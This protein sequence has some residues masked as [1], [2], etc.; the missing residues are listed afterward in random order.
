MA[1]QPRRERAAKLQ[2]HHRQRQ[3]QR[4]QRQQRQRQRQR[5]RQRRRQMQETRTD[6]PGYSRSSGWAGRTQGARAGIYQRIAVSRREREREMQISGT[7]RTA[8]R[9]IDRAGRRLSGIAT[10]GQILSRSQ[11]EARRTAQDG[12]RTRVEHVPIDTGTPPSCGWIDSLPA[13]AQRNS[14]VVRD[15]DSSLSASRSR[16]ERIDSVVRGPGDGGTGDGA[17]QRCGAAS[18]RAR[19][20]ASESGRLPPVVMETG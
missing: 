3:Q 8:G 16:H 17:R 5:H 4:Q 20:R 12:V 18:G 11:G 10:L 6:S 7:A 13:N 14:C 2:I 1:T 9:R 19:A 15:A